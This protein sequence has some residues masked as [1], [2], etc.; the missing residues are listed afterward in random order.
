MQEEPICKSCSTVG[1]GIKKLNTK[2]EKDAT[3]EEQEIV[4][5]AYDDMNILALIDRAKQLASEGGCKHRVVLWM[6]TGS[7]NALFYD[8]I[9]RGNVHKSEFLKA[10]QLPACT[11]TMFFWSKRALPIHTK[12]Y[13]YAQRRHC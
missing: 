3:Q 11:W 6:K 12:I 7:C 10:A 13:C 4:D 5:V 8:E 9:H 2:E 1:G